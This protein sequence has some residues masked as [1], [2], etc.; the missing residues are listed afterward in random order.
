MSTTKATT[1]ADWTLLI[2]IAGDN[3]LDS[4]GMKDIK[5]MKVH[6]SSEKI[7]VIVQRDTARLGAGTA[8]YRIKKGTTLAKDKLID[9]GETNTGD[10]AVLADFLAW[11]MKNYPAKRTMA[12]LWNHGSGWDDTDIYAEAKKRGLS[13]ATRPGAAAGARRAGPVSRGSLPGGFVKRSG[14]KRRFRGPL[15]LTAWQFE[16]GDGPRRAI[17]FDDDAQDFL[18]S[19][20]MKSV[21][22]TAAKNA[23]KK[24]DLIG[25]D[26][27]LMSMV[28][29]GMQVR[30]AGTVFCGSQEVEP[31]DGWPYE[32]ILKELHANPAMDGKTLA[33]LIAKQFVASYGKTEA[34]TQSAFDLAALDGVTKAA[35]ALGTKLAAVLKTSDMSARGSISYA[36]TISQGYEH[37]D[38]VDLCDFAANLAQV[39]PAA[40]AD[41]KAIT[42][43]VTACVFA[44]HAPNAQV[45]RSRGLSIYLPPA[46]ISPLYAKL[47]FAKGGW[48]K[49]LAA[50]LAKK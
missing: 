37:P 21:F 47:D 19:V 18:D 34:V 44:N 27:C 42:A 17:A 3:D 8:R 36:R 35:N 4:F 48:A 5:E 22:E 6:G 23:G 12:V 24:F 40:A 11:G 46:K 50:Y 43:A 1:T 41:L 2:Y 39:W 30:N 25:M 10:P 15:F 31:G 28:E 7:H 45:K 32:R 14:A 33:A 26:A 29:T 49:F 20:E 16:K 9:L 38:Y 13:P